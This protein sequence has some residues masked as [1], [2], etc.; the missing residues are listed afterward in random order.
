MLF[1]LITHDI[2]AHIHHVT[3]M[4]SWFSFHCLI[5]L[6]ALSRFTL[7]FLHTERNIFYPIY[8]STFCGFIAVI[9]GFPNNEVPNLCAIYHVIYVHVSYFYLSHHLCSCLSFPVTKEK[10]FLVLF[11]QQSTGIRFIFPLLLSPLPLI[12][13]DYGVAYW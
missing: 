4:N 8:R 11:T 5:Y 12:R 13:A 7:I 6:L 10:S 2:K 3:Y 1:C 9:T